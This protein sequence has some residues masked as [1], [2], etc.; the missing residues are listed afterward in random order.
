VLEFHFSFICFE[1]SY[2]RAR[3][4]MNTEELLAQL[5]IELTSGDDTRAEAAAL[6]IGK[7]G[8]QALPMLR[9]LLTHPKADIRWWSTRTLGEIKSAEAIDLLIDRCA[10]AEIN[11]RVCAIVALGQFGEQAAPA[12]A[13]LIERMVKGNVFEGTLAADTLAQIGT[14]A[15]DELVRVLQQGDAPMRG[16]AARALARIADPKS[17]PALIAA[18]D[19]ESPIVEHY[20]NEVLPKLGV[21]TILLKL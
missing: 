5:Q 20:A 21:G 7:L 6:A 19:D 11:L 15:T 8:A 3:P 4:K 12:V 10:D 14:A 13:A 17:I 18:L 2:Q 9:E 16:R 1:H